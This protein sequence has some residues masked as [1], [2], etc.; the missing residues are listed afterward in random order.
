M[1]L[2]EKL[3]TVIIDLNGTHWGVVRFRSGASK[4]KGVFMVTGLCFYC[5]APISGLGDWIDS[6]FVTFVLEA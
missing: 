6:K 3:V 5:E 1:L 2:A 4:L